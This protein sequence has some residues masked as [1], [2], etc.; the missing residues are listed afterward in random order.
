MTRIQGLMQIIFTK[1]KEYFYIFYSTT[2][3]LFAYFSVHNQ[4]SS[5]KHFKPFQTN[6][7]NQAKGILKKET[8]RKKCYYVSDFCWLHVHCSQ[9]DTYDIT[10]QGTMNSL[11]EMELAPM[12]KNNLANLPQW[13]GFQD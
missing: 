5:A 8:E 1:L 6:V 11:L 4:Y 12:Q 2:K 13:S 3:I 10:E 9:I 7:S